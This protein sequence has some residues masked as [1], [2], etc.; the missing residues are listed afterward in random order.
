MNKINFSF[1]E[2][3]AINLVK[4]FLFRL[5][6]KNST[7]LFLRGKDII[8][9]SP[10]IIGKHEPIL[11]C[12]IDAMANIGYDDFLI[13]IGANIGLCSC[14]NGA[15]FKQ[16]IAFEPN[17]LA[18]NILRVNTEI[19]IGS[20]NIEIN[21][22]GLGA[23][24]EELSLLIPKNN[25]GGA[26]IKGDQNNYSEEIIA[27]KDGYRSFNYENYIEKKVQI[28]KTT[29]VLEKRFKY[30]L[31]AGSSNG[32]IKID[33]EGMEEQVLK[34]IAKTLPTELEVIIIFENFDP[35]FPLENVINQFKGRDT[36]PYKLD[37]KLPYSSNWLWLI[38]IIVLMT[39]RIETKLIEVSESSSATG[40]IVLLIN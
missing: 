14:Q 30:L 35:E 31:D 9:I 22:F 15:S 18:A 11:T 19:A 40:D 16:I 34:G 1:K 2:Y 36:K 17:P 38:K 4:N 13:D 5:I 23:E 7:K 26:F 20:A 12:F 10:Q 28:K 37:R 6:T 27:K 24:N 29:E 39:S 3:N 8:S 33:V 25:W 21:E 32:V